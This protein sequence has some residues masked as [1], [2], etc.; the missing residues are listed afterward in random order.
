MSVTIATAGYDGLQIYHSDLDS[1]PYTSLSFWINGGTGG[2]QQLQI[3]GLAHEG[4]TNNFGKLSV[5]LGTPQTNTW[6]L[7]TI[8]LS[9]LGVANK[10]NFTG[11][12]IQSR[13]GAVQP[14]FY[15]DDIQLTPFRRRWFTSAS[16]PARRFAPPT[17][18][19]SV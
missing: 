17:R 1:S 9:S 13:I 14:T 19:G 3:Y 2:G 16:M 5:S 10:T 6:Q 4:T 12:V 18:A 8:P 15:L 11:F 7:I